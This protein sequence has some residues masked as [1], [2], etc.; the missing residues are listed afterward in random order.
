VTVVA[1]IFIILAGFAMV[2][3]VLQ[4]IMINLMFPVE[5]MNEAMKEAEAENIPAP[6][7]F[8]FS[9]VR[10][11]FFGFLVAS[12]TTFASAIGLLKRRNWARIVFIVVMSLGIA[13]MLFGVAMQFTMFPSGA[14]IPDD[15]FASRFNLMFNIM[16]AFMLIMATG[17]C[18]LFGWIIRRLISPPIKAEFLGS[19]EEAQIAEQ[20]AE[21]KPLNRT[22]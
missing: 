18:F 22:P 1:W 17:F 2:I 19:G 11:F 16:R 15:E 21:G 4:N 20:G 3:S 6:F 12:A 10:L 5:E 13:W 8:L 9:N 14:E 7:R